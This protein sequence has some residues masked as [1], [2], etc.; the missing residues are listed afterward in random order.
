MDQYNCNNQESY[1]PNYFQ[2][3]PVVFEKIFKGFP[4]GCHG[5]QNTAWN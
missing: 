3:G 1:V 5:N 4:F 2:I